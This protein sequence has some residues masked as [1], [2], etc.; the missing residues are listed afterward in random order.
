MT[1]LINNKTH[2]NTQIFDSFYGPLT[3]TGKT[4]KAVHPS[5]D[6]NG[7]RI[8]ETNLKMRYLDDIK[9]K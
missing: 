7:D 8:S 1:L 2:K 9:I 4:R 3:G 6:T 5:S